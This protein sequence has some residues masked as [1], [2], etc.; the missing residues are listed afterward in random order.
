MSNV[1]GAWRK[2]QV[3]SGITGTDA[4]DYFGTAIGLGDGAFA[5]GTP[6]AAASVSGHPAVSPVVS[7]VWDSAFSC[8]DSDTKGKHCRD[9]G[10]IVRTESESC[11]PGFCE[12]GQ[13]IGACTEATIANCS[14]PAAAHGETVEGTCDSY[15]TGSCEY[16]CYNNPSYLFVHIALRWSAVA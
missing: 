15:Y 11:L 6:G 10:A 13:C 2:T 5:V 16:A 8:I 9:N 7:R 12:D 14:L 1:R 3:I 4:S